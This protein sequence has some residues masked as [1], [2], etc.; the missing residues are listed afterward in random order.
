MYLK[1]VLGKKIKNRRIELGMDQAILSDYT[2]LSIAA[3][4]NIEN[5]KGNPTLDTIEKVLTPLG[6]DLNLQIK[7]RG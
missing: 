6:L 2:G 7:K 3:I 5:G 4:S 1:K